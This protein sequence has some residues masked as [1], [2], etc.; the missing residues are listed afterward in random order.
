M[1]NWS[2]V[3]SVGVCVTG[4]KPFTSVNGSGIMMYRYDAVAGRKG[5]ETLQQTSTEY[6]GGTGH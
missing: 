2:L 1:V 6:G 3:V 5:E 4:Q